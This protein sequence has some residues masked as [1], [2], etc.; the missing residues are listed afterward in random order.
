MIGAPRLALMGLL[1]WTSLAW[2]QKLSDADAAA[3]IEKTR[4]K[5]LDYSKSLPDFE[6]IEVVRRFSA[7][8]NRQLY[9]A[10]PDDKLT[11]KLRYFEHREEHKLVLFDGLPTDRTFEGLQGTIGTGEFGATLT[12][13]FDPASE[14][15]FHW[16]SWKNVRKHR[17][18]VYAYVVD[19]VHSR[20]LMM[21]GSP[22][23]IHQAFVG[24]RGAGH[25]QRNR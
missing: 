20:Y 6:C 19:P 12:A 24:Y 1:V 15:G 7:V 5:A 2:S 21:T 11:I 13:I 17:T 10:V 23:N 8:D 9:R 3:L 16:E 18:A 4:Q 14:T 22:T 25:R